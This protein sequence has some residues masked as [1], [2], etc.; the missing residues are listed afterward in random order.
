VLRDFGGRDPWHLCWIASFRRVLNFLLGEP[1]EQTDEAL[2]IHVAPRTSLDAGQS[3]AKL[4]SRYR[5]QTSQSRSDGQ[6][7]RQRQEDGCG[8]KTV[9]AP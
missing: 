3:E 5:P 6:R 8:I 1:A 4:V 7:V 9:L 2:G